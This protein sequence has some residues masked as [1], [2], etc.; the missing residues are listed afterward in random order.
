M[1]DEHEQEIDLSKKFP[2]MRPVK[3]VPE[4]FRINGC[5][6]AIYG[7]RDYDAETF[8]YVAT[9]CICLLF[10]P[11]FPIRAY[12]VAD[13]PEGGWY[14]IGKEP[15]SGVAKGWSAFSTIASSNPVLPG[16]PA[17]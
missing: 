7:R 3:S 10:I 14:F 6:V 2:K 17:A 5:G 11:V 9:Q 12:R 8:T 1:S 4:L 13:A 16:N 15:L